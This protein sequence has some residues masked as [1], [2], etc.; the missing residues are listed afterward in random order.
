MQIN[1]NMRRL[2]K[3]A[4]MSQGAL[5]EKMSEQGRPWHQTTVS[6]IEVG[7]QDLDSLEDVIALQG[8]LGPELIDGTPLARG[9]DA[10]ARLKFHQAAVEELKTIYATMDMLQRSTRRLSGLIGSLLEDEGRETF[11]ASLAEQHPGIDLSDIDDR[12][13]QL[14]ARAGSEP[15]RD[16][17]DSAARSRR[18][19]QEFQEELSRQE[20]KFNRAAGHDLLGLGEVPNPAEGTGDDAET[21]LQE[22]ARH[23]VDQETT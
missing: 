20:R 2:R 18:V 8:I 6:R 13:D 5:A 21:Y 3:A 14:F 17:E 9:M 15:L 11:K 19:I 16:G 4:K 12:L 10:S 23:G 22:R 1:E 7:S